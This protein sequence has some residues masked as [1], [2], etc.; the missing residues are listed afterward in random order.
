MKFPKD[1][2]VI[3]LT[4]GIGCGKSTFLNVFKNNFG[5]NYFFLCAD[6]ICHEVYN[7]RGN[8]L[9]KEYKKHWGEYFL[10]SDGTINRKEV[11]NKIFQ[12]E[13]IIEELAWLNN[14]LHPF[15]FKEAQILI[16]QTE[17]KFILF[18]IPLLFECNLEKYFDE[19]ISV[20]SENKLQ[21]KRLKERGYSEKEI[22]FRKSVQ[23]EAKEKLERADYGV[24]NNGSLDELVEQ[25]KIIDK[26]LR[27]KY[28]RKKTK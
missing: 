3:G 10:N 18:D 14:V 16:E 4:G 19:T 6:K 20:W 1:K 7:K 24:I 25:G 22:I 26:K 23:F 9:N 13:N 12:G 28:D 11:A 21:N 15:I 8:E 27:V 2:V 17:A 5:K